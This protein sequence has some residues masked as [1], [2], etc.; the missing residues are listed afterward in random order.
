MAQLRSLVQG[1]A[2][3]LA[4]DH[5]AMEAARAR[6]QGS[7]EDSAGED[8]EDIGAQLR[9]CE[10]ALNAALGEGQ[11]EGGERRVEAVRLTARQT[12][13]PCHGG[14]VRCRMRMRCSVPYIWRG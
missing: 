6:M 7:W 8:S 12:P 3:A 9:R 5:E 1:V 2:P 14:H 11:D 4:A 10:T 13:S